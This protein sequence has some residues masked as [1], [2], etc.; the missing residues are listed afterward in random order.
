MHVSFA[1]VRLL[2]LTIPPPTFVSSCLC[3]DCPPPTSMVTAGPTFEDLT[4]DDSLDDMQRIVRYS[5]SGIA[6]QRL[7]HVKMMATTAHAFGYV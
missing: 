2:S 6:L 3:L 4:F 5:G 1:I 7:V